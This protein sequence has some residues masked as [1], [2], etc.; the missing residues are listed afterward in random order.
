MNDEWGGWIKKKKKNPFFG[1]FSQLN[2]KSLE[3]KELH[4]TLIFISF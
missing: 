2:P 3:L 1:T 4:F